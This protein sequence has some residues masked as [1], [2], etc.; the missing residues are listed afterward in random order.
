MFGSPPPCLAA[1]MMARLSL[2]QS[3]P[4]L[5]SM[6]PFLCL[7]VAQ[8]E[9]PD[10]GWTP[11]CHAHGLAWAWVL[12]RHAHAKPWAWHPLIGAVQPLQFPLDLGTAGVVHRHLFRPRQ[13]QRLLPRG[14]GLGRLV[15]PG[16][17]VTQV[18]PNLRDVPGGRH[19]GGPFHQ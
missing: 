15:H 14:G 6:A 18:I 16:T 5:A 1:M 9:W 11:G 7:I 2:L 13:L 8:C 3:L 4:R 10:M 12:T 19:P 17:G